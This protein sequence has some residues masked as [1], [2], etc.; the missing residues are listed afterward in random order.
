MSPIKEPNFF[1]VEGESM[2]MPS[3]TGI[4]SRGF[5][6]WQF[7][8][9]ALLFSGVTNQRAIGEGSTLYITSPLAARR[10]KQSLPQSR[11]I[12]ILRQPADRA[13]SDYTFAQQRNL[14]TDCTFEQALAD[15]AI[16][17]QEKKPSFCHKADGYYHVQ[18]SVYYDLFPREQIK[19][20][21]YEDWIGAPQAMLRD[22]FRFLQVDEDFVPTILRSN[23]TRLPKS[24]R[25]HSLATHPPQL[26]RGMRFL[27]TT[28][29]RAVLSALKWMDNKFNLTS[30][31]PIDAEIRTRLTADYREDILKLQDLIGRD[32]SHG[33][34]T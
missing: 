32:L 19:I 12:A 34:K 28:A 6:V 16:C 18:L 33:L 25:L 24:R 11:L 22:L 14:E 9:Y 23:V 10:I 8:K 26:G 1:G 17:L 13:Y 3:P 4:R 29:R 20:Y 30:P 27:P 7:H 15:E 31:P 21:L 5:T 2:I